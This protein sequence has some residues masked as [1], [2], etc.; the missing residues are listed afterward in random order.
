MSLRAG[1]ST[2]TAVCPGCAG[3]LAVGE[4]EGDPLRVVA[5]A[6]ER[7][8][9]PAIPIGSRG[10]LDG[11]EWEVTGYQRRSTQGGSWPWEEY[12]LFNPYH[13]FRF[14]LRDHGAWSLYELL[15][16]DFAG[17]TPAGFVA[18]EAG[19][20]RTDYVLG[21][22]YWRVRV[23]DEV[24]VREHANPPDVLS[25]ERNGSEVTWSL[26]R[27]L[28][29][30]AV[31]DGFRLPGLPGK[32]PPAPAVRGRWRIAAA[33]CLLLVLVSALPFGQQRNQVV[34]RQAFEARDA[35]EQVVA[36][37][38]LPGRGGGLVVQGASAFTGPAATAQVKLL[39]VGRAGPAFTAAMTF[40]GAFGDS[41]P[42]SVTFGT[43]P[44][45][46]YRLAAAVDT[47]AFRPAPDPDTDAQTRRSYGL[48]L[49]AQP[50]AT[51]V[52]VPVTVTL[53][54]HPPSSG[55]LVLALLCVVAWPVAAAAVRWARRAGA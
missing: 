21:E 24:A 33:A 38:D 55:A 52:V 10:T 22:F 5:A 31:R 11:T 53:R 17:G 41:T 32:A 2:V 15:R 39:P 7:T 37:L 35:A 25:E 42:E 3:V 43:V 51:A 49:W 40:G 28:D 29:V 6:Q 30:A 13:G 8:E 4:G 47:A 34:L 27:A 45:G 48:E 46:R 20:A 44:G 18:G 9:V 19:T 54:R 16:R 50:P 12:L 14:L 1:G 26:G 36:E 23:G